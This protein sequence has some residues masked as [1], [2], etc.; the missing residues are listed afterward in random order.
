MYSIESNASAN[1]VQQTTD[2]GYIVA[3]YTTSFGAGVSDI[4]LIKT[5]A[6]GT[7]LWT[8]TY[9]GTDYES[10]NSVQQTFDGGY[11]VA[12]FTASF[13]AGSS[14]V[15]LIRTNS[16][17]DSLWTRTYGGISGEAGNSVQQTTDSGY[18]VAGYTVSFG[19]G[20]DDAYLIRTNSS[21]DTL[22]TRTYGG[23]FDEVATSV[24]QTS[25]E[26]YIMAGRTYSFGAGGSDVHLMKTLGDGTVAVQD[27]TQ[28]Y[29]CWICPYAE[30]PQP[31]Q[32]GN[33]DQVSGTRSK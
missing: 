10:A 16:S 17:G 6:S 15:Y 33:S 31:V 4:Y 18:I 20:S 13:G 26:G 29:P 28:R 21:G 27:E 9:G 8:K 11:I 7:T 32:S 30:L 5:D 12:G 2:G 25:D 3:G 22:W 24:Q 1:S 23:P 19:A 14:D